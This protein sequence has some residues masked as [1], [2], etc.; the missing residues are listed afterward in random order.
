MNSDREESGFEET[1]EMLREAHREAIPEAHFA[2]VRARVL[3]QLA[4]ERRP[5]WR[6]FWPYGFAAA[7]VAAMLL[8][9]FWPKHLAQRQTVGQALPPANRTVAQ[10][11]HDGRPPGLQSASVSR[12]IGRRK[13]LPHNAAYRVVGPLVPEHLV[14]KLVT[15]DPNVVIY[16]ITGE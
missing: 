16:W 15:N 10:A 12:V 11:G 6:G 4:A 2:A 5:W 14:V 1:L 13:R 7:A 9:A 8:A 3:S